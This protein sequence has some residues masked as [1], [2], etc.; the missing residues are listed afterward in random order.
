MSKPEW[1]L[2]QAIAPI[3]AFGSSALK[4]SD[5]ADLIFVKPWVGPYGNISADFYQDQRGLVIHRDLIQIL[6]QANA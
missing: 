5:T 3:Y 1:Q 6:P 2:A 4:V